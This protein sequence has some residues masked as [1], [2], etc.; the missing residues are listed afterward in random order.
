MLESLPATSWTRDAAEARRKVSQDEQEKRLARA[1][2]VFNVHN[3]FPEADF[4]RQIP[5]LPE[6]V[7]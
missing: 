6:N 5:A 2:Q 4:E 7:Q 1:K 3:T